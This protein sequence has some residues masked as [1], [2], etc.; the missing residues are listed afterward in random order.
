MRL[1]GRYNSITKFT[2]IFSLSLA[3]IVGVL[4]MP[5]FADDEEED[6]SEATQETETKKPIRGQV[7][8]ATYR[9]VAQSF[10]P[11]M[12]HPIRV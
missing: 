10:Y 7:Q 3:L 4:A 12:L 8:Q 5:A 2:S 9:M 6:S 1:F 11:P